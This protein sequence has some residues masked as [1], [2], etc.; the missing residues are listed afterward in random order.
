MISSKIKT[1]EAG[2]ASCGRDCPACGQTG[3]QSCGQKNDFQ[4]VGCRSFATVYTAQLPETTQSQDYDA[5]YTP[6][7]LTVP[8][9]VVLRLD[10]IIATFEPYRKTNRLLDVGCGAG[11]FLEA[12]TRAGLER[13]W[14]RSFANS[15]RAPQCQRF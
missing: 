11:T 10:E 9:I 2:A 4:L 6:E 13:N 7:N 3:G 1:D 15:G 5:Y 14:S 12:A 8:A